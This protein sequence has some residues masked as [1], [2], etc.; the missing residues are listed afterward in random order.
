MILRRDSSGG[1]L[2]VQV[3]ERLFNSMLCREIKSVSSS[4]LKRAA[5]TICILCAFFINSWAQEIGAGDAAHFLREGV[6]ARARALGGAYVALAT[7]TSAGYWNP[8]GLVQTSSFRLGGT[9]ES[10]YGGLAEFQ[11]LTGA[12]SWESLGAGFLWMNSEIHSVVFISAA[13][14][15]GDFSLGFTGKMYNFSSGLQSAHGLGFDVGLLYRLYF[16]EHQV[17]LGF[18]SADVGWTTIRWRGAGLSAIDYAAWVNRVGISVSSPGLLGPWLWAASLEVAFRRPPTPSEAD[19]LSKALQLS[20][21]LGIEMWFQYVVIRGGLADI[22][23]DET[24][25]VSLRLTAGIGLKMMGIM[26]DAAWT[27]SPLGYSYLF[28]VEFAF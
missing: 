4:L 11:Y 8:A 10:R 23:F 28:S 15:F 3:Q 12:V 21:A 1:Y 19:Y 22:H 26:F 2:M 14:N 27:T 18:S 6:G 20:L 7:D 5:I 9:Y 16:G 24:G 25:G 13:S 17:T